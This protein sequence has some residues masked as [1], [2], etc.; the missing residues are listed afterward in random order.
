MRNEREE[1]E[2]A[3]EEGAAGGEGKEG[4]ESWVIG[5]EKDLHCVFIILYAMFSVVGGS[6]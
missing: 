2:R 5:K 6:V 3:Q 1:R 4:R